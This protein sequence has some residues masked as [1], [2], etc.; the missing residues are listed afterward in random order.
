MIKSTD[1]LGEAISSDK[2]FD[3]DVA[4][5]S[6]IYPAVTLELQSWLKLCGTL[7]ECTASTIDF[8]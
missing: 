7:A 2:Q 4:V 8:W 1:V 6:N 5:T 3:D